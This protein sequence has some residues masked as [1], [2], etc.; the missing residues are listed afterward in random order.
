MRLLAAF[1]ILV[2]LFATGCAHQ[3]FAKKNCVKQTNLW[4]DCQARQDVF[5]DCE[6]CTADVRAC[7][8]PQ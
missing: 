5:S 6:K 8:D 7:E 1:C 4:C 2:S 3:R